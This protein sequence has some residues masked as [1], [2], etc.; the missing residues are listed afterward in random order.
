MSME[1][2]YKRFPR[3]PIERRAAAFGIDFVAVWFVSSLL[4]INVPVQMLVFSLLW[5][6]LRVVLV[7]NNQGQSLGSWAMD[8]KV[9][10]ARSS[11]VPGLLTLTKR[12]GIL[13]GAPSSRC[14]VLVSVL[15]TGFLSCC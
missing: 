13:G 2:I 1:P 15:R 11:R 14:W 8:M 7:S 4:A 12:E 6:G 3:V 9:L 10:E 5:L